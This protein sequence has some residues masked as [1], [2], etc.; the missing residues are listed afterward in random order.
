M[1]NLRDFTLFFPLKLG[2]ALPC[3]PAKNRRSTAGFSCAGVYPWGKLCYNDCMTITG[4][5]NPPWMQR[6]FCIFSLKTTTAR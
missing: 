4:E 2:K 5:R 6:F 3:L 1:A